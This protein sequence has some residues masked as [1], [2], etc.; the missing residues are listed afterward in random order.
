MSRGFRES[1]LGLVLRTFRMLT[2]AAPSEVWRFTWHGLIK[3]EVQAT[4]PIRLGKDVSIWR[5]KRAVFRAGRG[6][7]IASNTHLHIEG[8]LTLGEHVYIAPN[9]LLSAHEQLVIGDDT[10]I[11][12]GV[13]IRDNDHRFDRRDVPI[14]LQGHTCAPVVIERDVWIGSHAVVLKGVRIG[15]GAV[16]AAGA[17]VTKDV[18]PYAVVAGV[19]AKLLRYR[20]E[21]RSKH[22]SADLLPAAR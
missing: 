7:F 9:S 5:T 11:G 16:V 10:Q 15:T 13:S 19:P 21:I 8:V 20:G 14:R 18:P 1:R 6:V 17:V 22:E 3:G 12:D 2:Y 4:A